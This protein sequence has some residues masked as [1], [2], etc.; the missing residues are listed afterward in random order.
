[1]H[2]KRELLLTAYAAIVRVLLAGSTS[3]LPYRW[4]RPLLR[5]ALETGD[6][7]PQ[8]EPAH[9]DRV[10]LAVANTDRLL[11]LGRCLERSLTAWVM[12]R[13]RVPCRV[14]LSAGWKAPGDP[15]AHASLEVNGTVV[16]GPPAPGL[17][18]LEVRQ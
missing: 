7:Q 5:A 2:A 6:P 9:V 1:M 18:A 14:R 8:C 11:P 10:L 12:L 4:W 3:V 17:N 15:F 13:R 16:L